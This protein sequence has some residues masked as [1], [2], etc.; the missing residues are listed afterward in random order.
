MGKRC[1][2]GSLAQFCSN[3]GVF[4]LLP[5][6]S[7][8]MHVLGV[9]P[10]RTATYT[11][12][13]ASAL[14]WAC[15]ARFGLE[16]GRASQ[17]F[18]VQPP[19]A[20]HPLPPPPLPSSLNPQTLRKVADFGLMPSETAFSQSCKFLATEG[21]PSPEN[22]LCVSNV[23]LSTPPKKRHSFAEISTCPLPNPPVPAKAVDALPGRLSRQGWVNLAARA[24]VWL[25]QFGDE[26]TKL[27]F[28]SV[29]LFLSCSID[30]AGTHD[31]GDPGITPGPSRREPYQ[32]SVSVPRTPASCGCCP[33]RTPRRRLI[34]TPPPRP[35]TLLPL[36]A[37]MSGTC[38]VSRTSRRSPRRRKAARTTTR[39]RAFSLAACSSATPPWYAHFRAPRRPLV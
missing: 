36:F 17:R 38:A 2:I 21:T 26:H 25:S 6:N 9:Q 23:E 34:L 33:A 27:Q 32:S 7:W 19:T 24:G 8:G 37:G 11:E 30:T 15:R 14:Y 39:L 29:F 1:R 28:L 4:S 10:P 12:H 3:I 18:S 13:V 20:S 16:H 5:A 31:P 35:S 22:S